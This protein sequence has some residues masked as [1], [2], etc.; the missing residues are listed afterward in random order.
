MPTLG[1]A[2]ADGCA[3]DGGDVAA[4]SDDTAAAAA[5]SDCTGD[6][7]ALGALDA[8]LDALDSAAGAAL[9]SLELG[10]AAAGDCAD[11]DVDDDCA[12]KSSPTPRE[13]EVVTDNSPKFRSRFRIWARAHAT[14]RST[15]VGS[16]RLSFASRRSEVGL[17]V[18]TASK[19]SGRPL[20]TALK[21]SPEYVNA[22]PPCTTTPVGIVA[23]EAGVTPAK[24]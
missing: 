10:A 3:D 17:L 24:R 15:R 21:P 8:A 1:A 23:P 2:A 12:R 6:C 14:K 7:G 4:A 18:A 5:P 13:P 19:C 9:D 16:R 20:P 11:V 22:P